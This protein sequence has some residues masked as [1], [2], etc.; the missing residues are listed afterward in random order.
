VNLVAA[1]VTATVAA[2]KTTAATALVMRRMGL[3][4][5]SW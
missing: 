1:H 4:L 2:M 5:R 3:L